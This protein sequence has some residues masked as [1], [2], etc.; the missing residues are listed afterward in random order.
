MDY[1]TKGGLFSAKY[2]FIYA[3][4][5]LYLHKKESHYWLLLL[6]TIY[7]SV[8]EGTVSGPTCHFRHW[9]YKI[10]ICKLLKKNSKWT[11][12]RIFKEI[13]II[14]DSVKRLFRREISPNWGRKYQLITMHFEGDKIWYHCKLEIKVMDYFTKS[15]LFSA[16]YPFIYAG[17]KLCLHKKENHYWLLLLTAIYMTVLGRGQ[18]LSPHVTF[19]I[20]RIK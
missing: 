10:N 18:F 13:N 3:G 17:N 4:N 6:T 20:D 15:R 7:M 12:I 11:K 2:P 8:G 5:K 16:K 1:F 14:S 9:Q 19:D